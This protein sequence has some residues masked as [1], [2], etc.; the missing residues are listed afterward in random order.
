MPEG[1]VPPVH[2]SGGGW[3]AIRLKVRLYF[4]KETRTPFA[5]VPRICLCP[6][7]IKSGAPVIGGSIATSQFRPQNSA[8][9]ESTWTTPEM[10]LSV[11]L[12]LPLGATY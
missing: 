8:L 2:L 12:P 5:Y 9:Q 4:F 10:P 3:E 11:S 7:K 1:Q 6:R